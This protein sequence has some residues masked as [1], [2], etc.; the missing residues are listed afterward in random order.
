VR[1]T[2]ERASNA[3][4]GHAA[5]NGSAKK[6]NC[7]SNGANG[8][9]Q[10]AASLPDPAGD[11]LEAR[12]DRVIASIPAADKARIAIGWLKGVI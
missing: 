7:K 2:G 3:G 4:N 9:T 6:A 11:F 10:T 1:W 5:T 8:A 12:L